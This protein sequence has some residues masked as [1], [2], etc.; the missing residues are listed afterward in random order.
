MFSMLV[1]KN[2]SDICL[3]KAVKDFLM[4]S[5]ALRTHHQQCLLRG[6]Y[7]KL[8]DSM[9]SSGSYIACEHNILSEKAGF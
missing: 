6:Y 4:N 2:M 1:L 7:V 8:F 5:Y 9:S 3:K